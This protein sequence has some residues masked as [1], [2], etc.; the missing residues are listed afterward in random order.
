MLNVK[1][2]VEVNYAEVVAIGEKIAENE[3]D[4]AAIYI[5]ENVADDKEIIE[6]MSV[7]SGKVVAQ[8]FVTGGYAK[9]DATKLIF[10]VADDHVF[11]L[12]LPKYLDQVR[13]ENEF[14]DLL[15]DAIE[16]VISR[17]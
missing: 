1:E 8:G 16:D 13:E 17:F 15:S 6:F 4:Y 2:L 5:Y 14:G 9:L 12:D 7:K 11:R 3:L 10:D